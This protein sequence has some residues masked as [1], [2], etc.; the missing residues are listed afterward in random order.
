MFNTVV[1]Q[2]W[3]FQVGFSPL[4]ILRKRNKA[5]KKIRK[6]QKRGLLQVT[7]VSLLSPFLCVVA[8]SSVKHR[9]RCWFRFLYI[10]YIKCQ[11][12]K[13]CHLSI[14]VIIVF[15]RLSLKFYPPRTIFIIQRKEF[16]VSFS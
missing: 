14:N 1:T 4:R 5:L 9:S 2:Q 11:I 12:N 6:L 7:P 16:T 8:K 15:L 3:V 13:V 10:Y